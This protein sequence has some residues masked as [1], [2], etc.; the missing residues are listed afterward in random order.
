M[1]GLMQ[2][3]RLL[4]SSIISHAARWHPNAEVVSRIS[5]T[6]VHRTNYANLEPDPETAS[7]CLNEMGPGLLTGLARDDSLGLSQ[8]SRS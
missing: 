2:Q 6:Q 1:L 4:L 7:E 5:E 8:H 3:Q